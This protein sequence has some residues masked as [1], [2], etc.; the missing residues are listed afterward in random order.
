MWRTSTIFSSH[1][2][3]MIAQWKAKAQ[4]WRAAVKI[5]ELCCDWLKSNQNQISKVWFEKIQL[6]NPKDDLL[7]RPYLI[8]NWRFRDDIIHGRSLTCTA[9]C[10]RM[11]RASLANWS[12]HSKGLHSFR[13]SS[14]ARKVNTLGSIHIWHQ[15]FLGYFWPKYLPTQI[16]W[17]TT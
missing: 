15:M 8:A 10:A 17:F 12:L 1:R 7:N 2:I 5:T 16:R 13:N 11:W 6:D 3:M 4:L 14:W 9:C